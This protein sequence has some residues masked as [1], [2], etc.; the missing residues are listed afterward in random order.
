[1]F[2]GIKNPGRDVVL[3]IALAM[4]LDL[5]ETQHLLRI[6]RMACLDARNRRDSMV[7]FGIARG[8]SVAEVNDILYEFGEECL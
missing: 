5:E 3:C 8:I 2:R 1:M 7:I 4:K 6:G